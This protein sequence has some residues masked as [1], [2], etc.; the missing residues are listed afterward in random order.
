[1][2]CRLTTLEKFT[3]FGPGQI[4]TAVSFFKNGSSY[5]CGAALLKPIHRHS[6]LNTS[7]TCLSYSALGIFKVFNCASFSFW[8]FVDAVQIGSAVNSV[9]DSNNFSVHG[10]PGLFLLILSKR[11]IS[12]VV[13][14][15]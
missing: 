14:F 10:L 8:Y 3:M 7:S 13:P 5:R 12:A 1:M 6:L 11:S 15:K 4:V 9:F 2:S